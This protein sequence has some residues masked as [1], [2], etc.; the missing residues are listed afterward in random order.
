MPHDGGNRAKGLD[1][2]D[3]GDVGELPDR[4]P[5]DGVGEGDGGVG[6]QRPLEGHRH[7]V[8]HRVDE[9]GAGHEDGHGRGD[10][11]GS[12][13]GAGGPA[14]EVAHRHPGRKGEEGRQADP[15]DE[16]EAERRRSRRPHGLG[17]REPGG[18]ADGSCRS[19][20]RGAER[21]REGRCHRTDVGAV[22]EHREAEEVAV[23]DGH[24]GPEE[25][26]QS[27]TDDGSHRGHD[28]GEAC[29]VQGDGAVPVA[30][31]LQ[32]P[33]LGALG[34]DEAGEGDRHEEGRH[35]EE[36]GRDDPGHG[37]LLLDLAAHEAMGDLEVAP[38][39]PE[40]AVGGEDAVEAGDDRRLRRA[41]R[42]AQRHGVEGALHVERR[43][44]RAPRHPGDAEVA[45][46]G[47]EPPGRDRV[48]VLGGE[49]HAR[50]QQRLAP[51]VDGEDHPVARDD[52]VRGREALRDHGLA[53]HVGR[54]EPSLTEVDPVQPVPG[55]GPGR[56]AGGGPT[57][58]RRRPAR[59]PT[60][61]VS[62]S[63]T[64]GSSA[65]RCATGAGTRRASAKTSAKRLLRVV[66]VSA[67]FQRAPRRR[68]ADEA[69]RRRRP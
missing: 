17:G 40:P 38:V 66:Q 62:T 22:V 57:R 4:L 5:G 10:P 28:E 59:P 46:V 8:L 54:R 18:G 33:D 64:P 25:V 67:S 26:A 35:A 20:R 9:E 14:A 51:A 45:V 41:G 61:R 30:E 13:E 56:R 63:A 6:P 48:D 50:H 44:E 52:A 11:E 55:R 49:D 58:R 65:M 42:E 29:V 7:H 68:G 34:R 24:R 27:G 23:H 31:R 60:T 43:L 16:G 32:G 69:R 19:C 2:E 15:L 37:P 39:R 47:Q 36:D 21:Q 53:A 12:E 1:G 3:A